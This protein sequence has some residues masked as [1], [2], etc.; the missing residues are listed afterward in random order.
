[1]DTWAQDEANKAG[2][3]V[4]KFVDVKKPEYFSYCVPVNGDLIL[5][6]PDD[7]TGDGHGTARR[8]ERH[9]PVC[10]RTDSSYKEGIY[11]HNK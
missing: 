7:G 5:F 6:K 9:S 2:L 1:M 4:G 3:Q 10:Q 8:L 11:V